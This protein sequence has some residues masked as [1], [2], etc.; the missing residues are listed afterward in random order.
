VEDYPPIEN[1][2]PVIMTLSVLGLAVAFRWEGV[3]GAINVG[4]FLVHYGVFWAIRGEPFPFRA[5]PML[6]AAVVPG[7]LFLVCWW[8]TRSL[9]TVEGA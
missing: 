5:V 8:S 4:L 1:L 9:E 7:V 3:G 2:L 6:L